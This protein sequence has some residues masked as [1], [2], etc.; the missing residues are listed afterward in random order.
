M[1]MERVRIRAET[2]TQYK[3]RQLMKQAEG[4]M[5]D[6][7]IILYNEDIKKKAYSPKHCIALYDCEAGCFTHQQIYLESLKS[8]GN[9]SN[10]SYIDTPIE[11]IIH[12]VIKI[13][14]GDGWRVK[15]ERVYKRDCINVDPTMNFVAALILEQG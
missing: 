8:L 5:S 1:E 10:K 13:L 11:A 2:E 3:K 9:S 14:E 7:G 4:V 12:E 15:E 6:I